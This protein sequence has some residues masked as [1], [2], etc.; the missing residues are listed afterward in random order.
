[1]NRHEQDLVHIPLVRLL[2]GDPKRGIPAALPPQYVL[3]S[4]KNH[5]EQKSKRMHG[6]HSAMG[7]LKGMS[8]LMIIG[9]GPVVF[10]IEL[11]AP[12]A[13]LPSGNLSRAKPAVRPEQQAVLDRLGACGCH[14]LV[15]NNVKMVCDWLV[16]LGVPLRVRPT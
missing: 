4:T 1:M 5:G 7:L 12:P 9:P 8:D 10:V 15:A 3:F 14:V 6:I 2:N 11:K 16:E 13:V